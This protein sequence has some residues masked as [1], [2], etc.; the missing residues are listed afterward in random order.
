MQRKLLWTVLVCV[1]SAAAS[2]T[3]ITINFENLNSGNVLGNQYSALGVA[4]S[5]GTILTSGISLNEFDFPPHSGVNVV[6]D[7]SGPITLT[8]SHSVIFVSAFFTYSNP[9]TMTAYGA[10]NQVLGTVSSLFGSNYASS[11]NGFPNELIKF[12][13]TA[14]IYRINISGLPSGSSF[15]MDDLRWGSSA[16][17]EPGTMVL[18]A[19]GLSLIAGLRRRKVRKQ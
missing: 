11:G 13:S 7:L 16:V 17:P 2:A 18:L 12:T 5:G 14:G 15:V 9:I 3:S 19:S 10:N 4:F 1:L 8:F 6:G